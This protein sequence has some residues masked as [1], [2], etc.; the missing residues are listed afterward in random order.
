[1]GPRVRLDGVSLAY[2]ARRRT[3]SFKE[4]VLQ[5]VRRGGEWQP[6]TALHGIDL[7]IGS[8]EVVGI[9]GANGAG[10]S[11][12]LKVV[13]GLLRPTAGSVA[14][15]G[16]VTPVLDVGVAGDGE[17]TGHENILLL[18]LL[19]GRPRVE[20]EAARDRI[21]EFAGLG[22]VV[23]AT[24]ASY[25]TG[26]RQ[27]L[28]LSVALAWRPDV[29]LLD[30]ALNAG[31]AAFTARCLGRVRDFASAGSSVII[32]SHD[33]H[34]IAQA[35]PRIIWLEG[36]AIREDAGAEAVLEAYALQA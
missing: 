17:L 1:M 16:V 11:T 27:R 36:G 34:L 19:F 25:S 24:L 4:R 2:R 33:A 10:K 12:L 29:L 30:E 32:T 20:I 22:E 6:V 21:V 7:S 28:L 15:P 3:T 23:G 26:M 18:G 5:W 9:V 13:A 35:A 14:V 8:G 31:D